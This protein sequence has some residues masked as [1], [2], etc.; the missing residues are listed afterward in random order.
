MLTVRQCEAAEK[1]D[2]PYK[3]GDAKGLYLYVLPS[4]HKSWRMKYRFGGK[5]KRLVFGAFPEVKLSTARDMRDQAREQLRQGIDPAEARKQRGAAPPTERTFEHIARRW[6]ADQRPT[7]KEKHA[8]TVLA[9]LEQEVFPTI[10]H[11]DVAKIE[12]TEVLDLIEKIQDRGAIET[13][14]R[15]LGRIEAVFDLAKARL[16]EPRINPAAGVA[17]ALKP[18]KKGRR[19]A[20]TSLDRVREFLRKVEERPGQP[21]VKL[22]SRLLAITVVRPGVIRTTPNGG[23][24]FDLNL[25]DQALWRIPPQRMKLELEESEDEAF[26]MLVPLTWQA[27]EAIEAAQAVAGRSPWLFPGIRTN[28]Q[29]I[30]DSTLSR[31]YGRVEGF[32]GEHV[33]HGWRS[34][35]STI[36]NE[37][38]VLKDRP[39]DAEVIE[40]MLSHK[41]AGVRGIYNRAAYM[42]RRREIAQEWADMLLEGFPRADELA[43]CKRH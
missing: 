14:H 40:L 26:E 43:D 6:Y 19:P 41:I 25:P 21:S 38:A 32:E 2:K 31:L 29:P 39:G 16:N 37:L 33:P 12:A 24:F 15:V 30:T 22:A 9:S 42:K 18:V 10:G 7:W 5:E 13:A 17:R 20:I 4:G 34:T 36:M 1:R 23:E 3:L 27:I 8:K 28:R 35:F 11:R